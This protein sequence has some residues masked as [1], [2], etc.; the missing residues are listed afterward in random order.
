MEKMHATRYEG[1]DTELPGPLAVR[2]PASTSMCSPTRKL[3]KK[4]QGIAFL[5]IYKH[6]FSV[7][8]LEC[9]SK[10][11]YAEEKKDEFHSQINVGKEK[12]QAFEIFTGLLRAFNMYYEFTRY[13]FQSYLTTEGIS[14]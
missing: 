8:P 9:W 10:E 12:H 7:R 4:R 3:S 1:R 6:F 5:I 11:C 2:H 14:L 13:I